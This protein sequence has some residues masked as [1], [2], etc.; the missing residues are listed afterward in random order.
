[1]KKYLG[2]TASEWYQTNLLK[3]HE[4]NWENWKAAFLKAF[5]N[6][7][8]SAA[9][10]A[11]NFKYISGS[12]TEYAIEKER[13]ILEA[14][15]KTSEET[16]INLIVIGLPIHIQDEIDKEAVQSTNDLIR[17]LGQYEDQM[18]G[19]KTQENNARLDRKP[20]PPPK[21]QLCVIC[22]ALNFP[23]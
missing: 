8:W 15:R 1:M 13:L 11:Y 17:L 10:Y 22:E 23:G 7:G 3:D 9:Q 12:F 18:K 21:E 4:Y 16:R 5:N 6:K 2:K 19:R 20:E 14:R